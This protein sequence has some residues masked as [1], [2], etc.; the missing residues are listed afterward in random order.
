MNAIKLIAF[1][2]DGTLLNTQKEIPEENLQALCRA[3]EKGIEVVPATGRFFDAMPEQIRN[4]PFLH[5]AITVNGAKVYDCRRKCAVSQADLSLAQTMEILACL[6]QY[7]VIY[8]CYINDRAWADQKNW[9][10]LETY[11]KDPH[12]LKMV[13]RTRKPVEDLKQFLVRQGKPVQKITVFTGDEDLR[14]TLYGCMEAQVPG[15]IVSSSLPGN[16]DINHS[17]A[18]KG[19]AL[20]HLSELLATAPE[21][22]MAFGDGL[23]DLQM[24]QSA[25]IGVA[26]ENGDP[27]LKQS[28]DIIADSCDNNGVAKVINQILHQGTAL[29]AHTP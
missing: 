11:I 22:T 5:Y 15:T 13:R 21:Q 10:K 2:L 19:A 6:E 14:Q 17:S 8:D 20:L 23:N 9:D 29:S 1:D 26:M 7:P 16:I 28:A 24:I 18:N 25:G 12:V 4:L 3:A 27:R